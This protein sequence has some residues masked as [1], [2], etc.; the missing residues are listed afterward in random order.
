MVHTTRAFDVTHPNTIFSLFIY[1]ITTFP[2]WGI[3][4]PQ[5][6]HL[7]PVANV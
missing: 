3:F 5:M 1:L 7:L 6:V 4:S 2:L